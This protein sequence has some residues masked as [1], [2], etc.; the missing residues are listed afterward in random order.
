MSEGECR[1]I[2]IVCAADREAGISP[3]DVAAYTSSTSA[4]ATTLPE[5]RST[6]ISRIHPPPQLLTTLSADRLPRPIPPPEAIDA[7]RAAHAT[8]HGG[9]NRE[10]PPLSPDRRRS[11]LSDDGYWR[12][13]TRGRSGE[14]V[15]F[16]FCGRCCRLRGGVVADAVDG[17][18]RTFVSL[19]RD[20]RVCVGRVAGA[21]RRRCEGLRSAVGRG[22]PWCLKVEGRSGA[23]VFRFGGHRYNNRLV[24]WSS[25]NNGER[26]RMTFGGRKQSLITARGISQQRQSSPLYPPTRFTATHRNNGS[27]ANQ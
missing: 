25:S 8:A 7:R 15:P 26:R 20:G 14:S 4:S 3:R 27:F 5:R 24:R 6:H 22:F 16:T 2:G 17:C 11:A 23:D 9:N 21:V 13:R 12:R 1:R 19:R 10:R 18:R